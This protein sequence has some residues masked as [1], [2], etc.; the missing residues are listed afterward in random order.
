MLA[1]SMSG[2]STRSQQTSCA[3]Q[4]HALK[5]QCWW[6]RKQRSSAACRSR[7]VARS[8]APVCVGYRCSSTLLCLSQ[9]HQCQSRW[10]LSDDPPIELPDAAAWGTI[11]KL[12]RKLHDRVR[13]H[14]SLHHSR[15]WLRQTDRPSRCVLLTRLTSQCAPSAFF[16]PFCVSRCAGPACLR[17]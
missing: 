11:G 6:W 10:E 8:A 3:V 12:S 17:C 9:K 7:S 5:K 15:L 16:L 1:T 4:S 14:L 2:V 13:H